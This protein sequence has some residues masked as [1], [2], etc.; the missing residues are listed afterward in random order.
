MI[1]RRLTPLDTATVLVATVI[2]AAA[3]WIALKGP[4]GPLAMHFDIQGRPNRWG[5]RHEL[6]GTL[7]LMSGLLG[8]TAGG[9][10][11]FAVRAGDPA[12]RRS[13]RV[14]QLVSVLSIAVV[15]A[16]L[17]GTILGSPQDGAATTGWATAGLGLLLLV[18]G[19]FLGRVGPNPVIGVRTPWNF[20]SRLAWD[21][22]NRLAGRLFFWLGLVGILVGPF[23]P[24]AVGMTGLVVAIL[25]A[26]AWSAFESWRVW[27]TDPDRQPF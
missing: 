20:K 27:R 10:S 17:A 3:I 19:A 2:L 24:P 25:V 18:I 5:D 23:A 15:S 11:W 13:L 14:G 8:A 6:A 26:A 4:A 16:I 21:R 22:S 1:D 7:A 12:R 9:M